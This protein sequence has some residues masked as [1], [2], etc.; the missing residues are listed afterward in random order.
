MRIFSQNFF[1]YTG[2]E[3]GQDYLVTILMMQTKKILL[4]Y[5]Y[6]VNYTETEPIL[7]P[8]M[9]RVRITHTK[10]HVLSGRRIV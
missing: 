8:A 4:F 9:L 5:Y 3:K 10:A 6:S 7:M 2:A 1:C